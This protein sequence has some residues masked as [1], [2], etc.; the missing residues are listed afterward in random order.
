M[1]EHC[2]S[3]VLK[4]YN[5]KFNNCVGIDEVGRGPLAGPV[6]ASAVVLDKS[7]PIQGLNDSKKLSPKKRI[8]LC[9]EIRSKALFVEV[10]IIDRDIID[11][12]NIL[13]A[14]LLAMTEAYNKIYNI[15]GNKISAVFIDGNKPINIDKKL[16]QFCII[17]GDSII[18]AIM[19]AS[20][21]AKVTRDNIMQEAAKKYPQYLF[22]KN[23]GYPTK[24]H[25]QA[26]KKH[27]PCFLHR[28]S[29]KPVANWKELGW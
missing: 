8:Q 9:D 10:A 6:V 2:Y 29:F 1:N 18:P 27:G 22:E 25:F 20:I 15:L 11:N 16:S 21:I 28:N 5:E 14:S 17:G 4:I 23:M 3:D 24:A 13:Q 12:I 19:A 26:L 7:K